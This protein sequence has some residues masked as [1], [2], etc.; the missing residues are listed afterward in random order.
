MDGGQ[1]S[2][3][4]WVCAA[5]GIAFV[6]LSA[7]RMWT[8]LNS[9]MLGPA[10]PSYSTDR[11]IAGLSGIQNGSERI[12]QT[13]AAL[14]SEKRLVIL[15]PDRDAPS[16]YFTSLV[17]YLCWPRAVEAIQLHPDAVAHRVRQLDPATFAGILFLRLPPPSFVPKGIQW[18]PEL[19]FVP[20]PA[21]GEGTR[22]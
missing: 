7:P 17:T 3:H 18:A 4:A 13:L 10:E 20:S 19:I 15:L 9:G 22:P 12:R 1:G 21:A 14:P 11:D 2:V 6:G 5:L 8:A 16:A